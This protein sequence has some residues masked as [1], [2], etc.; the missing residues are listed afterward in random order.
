[1]KEGS[2]GSADKVFQC[3]AG[4]Y[5]LAFGKKNRRKIGTSSPWQ[6]LVAKYFY[7]LGYFEARLLRLLEDLEYKIA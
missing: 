3:K 1:M 7:T 2:T 4:R 5:A 6:T